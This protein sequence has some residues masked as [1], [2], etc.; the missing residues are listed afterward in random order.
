MLVIMGKNTLSDHAKNL[1]VAL[2][3][4]LTSTMTDLLHSENEK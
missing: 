2:D 4:D 1:G 3:S